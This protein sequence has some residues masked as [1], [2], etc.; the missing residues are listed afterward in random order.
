MTKTLTFAFVTGVFALVSVANANAYT[1]NGSVTGPHGGTGSVSASG[2]CSGHLLAHRQTYR[3]LWRERLSLGIGQL[4][5]GHLHRNPHDDRPE[6]RL[7]RSKRQHLAIMLH[8]WRET[9]QT[10]PPYAPPSRKRSRGRIAGA[11]VHDGQ[12]HEIVRFDF[13][14]NSS[15]DALII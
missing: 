2:G 14:R 6:R 3:A 12:R 1:R 15:D 9:F 13:W 8:V 11:F 5:L 7:H 10:R 4:Q